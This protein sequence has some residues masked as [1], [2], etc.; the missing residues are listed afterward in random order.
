[1]WGIALLPSL[2]TL[3]YIRRGLNAIHRQIIHILSLYTAP[4]DMDGNSRRQE[5]IRVASWT[6]VAEPMWWA[7]MV[8][9]V[10]GGCRMVGYGCLQRTAVAVVVAWQWL[11]WHGFALEDDLQH[12]H[13]GTTWLA[14]DRSG[15]L[16]LAGL[17]GMS[18]KRRELLP[19]IEHQKMVPVV[20]WWDKQVTW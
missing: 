18:L 3:I 7:F 10:D 15:F 19:S 16:N 20:T 9:V 12:R 14:V 11:V 4:S 6:G 17:V 2:Y 13:C 1:M 5:V 8:M